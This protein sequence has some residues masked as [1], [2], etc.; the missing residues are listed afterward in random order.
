VG[1]EHDRIVN[2]PEQP[3]PYVEAD[4]TGW[5]WQNDQA[6]RRVGNS[7]LRVYDPAPEN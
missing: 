7:Y 5:T 2:H 4:G 1:E 6:W 3:G